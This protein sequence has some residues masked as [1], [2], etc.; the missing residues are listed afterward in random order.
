MVVVDGSPVVVLLEVVVGQLPLEQLVIVA[1][2]LVL[3]VLP[4]S[5]KSQQG[6][7]GHSAK[8]Q[9]VVVQLP[10]PTKLGS[11]THLNSYPS[12]KALVYTQVQS[13]VPEQGALVPV[14]E[15]PGVDVVVNGSAVVVVVSLA[16]QLTVTTCP[17]SAGSHAEL[18]VIPAGP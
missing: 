7:L 18:P 13:V 10:D 9:H 14:V 1:V 5:A 8:R 3:S 2:Q 11:N 12:P 6:P 17:Q 4:T 15:V 16:M